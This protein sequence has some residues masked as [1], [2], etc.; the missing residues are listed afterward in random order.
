MEETA[1]LED[2]RAAAPLGT[3]PPEPINLPPG[4][5]NEDQHS[6]DPDSLPFVLNT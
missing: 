2:R 3:A 5:G 6:L 1:C 4:V